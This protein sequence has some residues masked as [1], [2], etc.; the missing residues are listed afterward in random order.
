MVWRSGFAAAPFLRLLGR[1][2]PNR[3]LFL[4]PSGAG[5]LTRISLCVFTCRSDW[6]FLLVA[7]VQNHLFAPTLAC[8]GRHYS[9]TFFKL[10]ILAHTSKS[11]L[12]NS[13]LFSCLRTNSLTSGRQYGD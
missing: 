10:S 3:T 5:L 6:V 13:P 9:S 2:L 8:C 1:Q 4:C 12:P 7:L 11:W